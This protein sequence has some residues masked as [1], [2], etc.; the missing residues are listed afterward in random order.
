MNLRVICTMHVCPR[1]HSLNCDLRML[2]RHPD[3]FTPVWHLE[4]I[5]GQSEPRARAKRLLPTPV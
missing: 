4:S 5:L 1:I 3:L 2:Q